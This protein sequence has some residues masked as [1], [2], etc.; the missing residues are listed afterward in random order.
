MSAWTEIRDGI[1][2]VIL[3][4]DHLERLSVDFAKFSGQLTDH[5]RRLV[6]IETMIEVARRRHLPG[7]PEGRT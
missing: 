7:D 2:K 5:E 1:R 4:Q 3:M 6:R